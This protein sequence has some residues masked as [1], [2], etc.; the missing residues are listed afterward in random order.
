LWPR[1]LIEVENELI[2]RRKERKERGGRG[3][4]GG[5]GEGVFPNWCHVD[6]EDV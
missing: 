4:R 5:R 1:G 6:I 3:G 2:A